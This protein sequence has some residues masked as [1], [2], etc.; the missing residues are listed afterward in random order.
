MLDRDLAELYGVT[1]GRLNEQVKRNIKRF[2]EDFMFQLTKQEIENLKSQ[3]VISNEDDGEDI[4]FLRSQ[5]VTLKQKNSQ[6]KVNQRS[7]IAILKKGQGKHLKY[8]PYA[9]SEHGV[10]MLSSVLKSERAIQINIAIIKT[11]IKIRDFALSYK[12][13]AEKITE[14]EFQYKSQ[15]KRITEVFVALKLLAEGGESDNKKEEIGFKCK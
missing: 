4:G 9:F 5:I 3:I 1:T 10:A 11:F 2:P 12:L 7:Q 6:D 15:D 14:L 8:L 13:L